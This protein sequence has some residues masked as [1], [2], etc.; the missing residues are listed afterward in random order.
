MRALLLL[1]ALVVAACGPDVDDDDDTTAADDDD[2]TA[3]DDDDATPDPDANCPDPDLDGQLEDLPCDP[4]DGGDVWQFQI[5]TGQQVIATVDTVAPESTFDPRLRIVDVIETALE[6]GDDDCVCSYEVPGDD[7][8]TKGFCCP[9]GLY[10]GEFD[11][12]L[13]IHV[14]SFLA[15]NCTA[16]DVGAYQL[17]VSIDGVEILPILTVDDGPTVFGG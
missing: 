12:T 4:D 8:L 9:F 14:S 16:G 10:T 5:L 3:G 7:C 2:A 1:L 6:F 13:R 15:E 11:E 17:R